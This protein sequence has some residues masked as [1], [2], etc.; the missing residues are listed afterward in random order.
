VGSIILRVKLRDALH[1]ARC[2][3]ALRRECDSD[4]LLLSPF[5]VPQRNLFGV[6]PP[7]HACSAR[8]PGRRIVPLVTHDTDDLVL[9]YDVEGIRW[10]APALF[11]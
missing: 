11:W 3:R 2:V 8:T 10:T 9:F 6:S 5:R 1:V 7:T 4:T